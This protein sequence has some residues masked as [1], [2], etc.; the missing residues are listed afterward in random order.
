MT[1]LKKRTIDAGKCI[2]E[3]FQLILRTDYWPRTAA[4]KLEAAVRQTNE[5]QTSPF[6][7]KTKKW[8]PTQRRRALVSWSII[9]II[10]YLESMSAMNVKK[11]E[12]KTNRQQSQLWTPFSRPIP[13]MLAGKLRG[14]SRT[15]LHTNSSLRSTRCAAV[16][17]RYVAARLRDANRRILKLFRRPLRQIGPFCSPPPN[18]LFVLFFYENGTKTGQWGPTDVFFNM[19]VRCCRYQDRWIGEWSNKSSRNQFTL[20]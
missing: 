13:Q 19:V 1:S 6:E 16:S 15:K 12:K 10:Y 17:E 4:A 3:I 14:W 11:K 20:N 2:E 9:Y 18:R 7:G 8:A 5:I